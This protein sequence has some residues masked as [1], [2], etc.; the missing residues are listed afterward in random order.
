MSATLAPCMHLVGKG[1]HADEL[2][3]LQAHAQPLKVCAYAHNKARSI[4]LVA[5]AKVIL[6]EAWS[7]AIMSMPHMPE[8]CRMYIPDTR[9]L[10]C[11][12]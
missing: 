11:A 1:H 7:Q 5:C 4:F 10:F 8:G 12:R 9:L 2:G 3:L 6:L